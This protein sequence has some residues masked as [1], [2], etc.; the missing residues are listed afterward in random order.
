[1]ADVRLLGDWNADGIID[2]RDSSAIFTYFVQSCDL[3]PDIPHPDAETIWA[4]DVMNFGRI[5]IC[6]ATTMGCIYASTSVESDWASPINQPSDWAN[7]YD[8][9]YYTASD[10]TRRKMYKTQEQGVDP[11]DVFPSAPPFSS[12]DPNYVGPY[13]VQTNYEK[14]NGNSSVDVKPYLA[15]LP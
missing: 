5:T 9:F 4:G 7:N 10:G 15:Q 6:D 2:Q 1:M 12:S 11:R 3:N 13:W 14:D 8:K